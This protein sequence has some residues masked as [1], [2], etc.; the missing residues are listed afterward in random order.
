MVKQAV[1]HSRRERQ[2]FRGEQQPAASGF[3][4]QPVANKVMAELMAAAAVVAMAEAEM[5]REGRERTI[6]EK[7]VDCVEVEHHRLDVVRVLRLRGSSADDC[8]GGGGSE[9][10]GEGEGGAEAEA[11]AEAEVESEAE[12]EPRVHVPNVQVPS[13]HVCAGCAY[14][15]QEACWLGCRAPWAWARRRWA[16]WWRWRL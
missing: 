5:S 15:C 4:Q 2:E 16:R 10:E 13:V 6:A 7:H 11:E 3:Q 12:A 14:R 8:E 9:A 1:C